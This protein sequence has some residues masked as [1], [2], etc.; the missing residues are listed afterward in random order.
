MNRNST[1]C[2]RY[3]D[4]VKKKFFVQAIFISTSYVCLSH[5]N[6]NSDLVFPESILTIPFCNLFFI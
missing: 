2:Y 1:S 3:T 5:A 4:F 6:P